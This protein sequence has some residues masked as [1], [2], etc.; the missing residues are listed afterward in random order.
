MKKMLV[1]LF[2]CLLVLAGCSSKS[3][4]QGGGAAKKAEP[5]VMKMAVATSKDRSL[6]KG[7][8]KFA[9]I[10]EKRDKRLDQSRSVSG[11]AARGRFGG[12]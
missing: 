3:E 1:L 6:T 9:E 8:Y 12:V 4:P 5:K 2:A 11:W 10:V 7:L